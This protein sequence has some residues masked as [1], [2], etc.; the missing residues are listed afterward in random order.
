LAG[1]W[2]ADVIRG[3]SLLPV[4][5]LQ[6][7]SSMKRTSVDTVALCS[8]VL[9]TTRIRIGT[10]TARVP[11]PKSGQLKPP[12]LPMSGTPTVTRDVTMPLPLEATNVWPVTAVSAPLDV[13]SVVPKSL[14]IRTLLIVRPAACCTRNVA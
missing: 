11:V 6:F 14:S 9:S 10:W 8:L 7:A 12:G 3:Q 5:M 13:W 4:E 1:A 2:V